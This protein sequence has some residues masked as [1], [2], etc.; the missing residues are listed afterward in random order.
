VS[1][2]AP[3]T[4]TTVVVVVLAEL[5]P[6][7][8]RLVMPEPVVILEPVVVLVE[9]V[10]CALVLVM[11]EPVVMLEPVAVIVE[12]V[13]YDLMVAMLELLVYALVLPLL[14]CR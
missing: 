6:C 13:A 9:P 14:L 7:F 10:P 5:V 3:I 12:P 4:A 11:P 1:L 2:S 8:L